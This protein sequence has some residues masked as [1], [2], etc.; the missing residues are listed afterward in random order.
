MNTKSIIEYRESDALLNISR[1]IDPH[2]LEHQI[3]AA[4]QRELAR[5]IVRSIKVGF[6]GIAAVFKDASDLQEKHGNRNYGAV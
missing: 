1:T 5:A 6:N 2:V 3:R 4:A